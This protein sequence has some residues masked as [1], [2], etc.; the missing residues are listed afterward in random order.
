[1]VEKVNAPG[2]GIFLPVAKKKYKLAL[3]YFYFLQ[4]SVTLN[5]V[6]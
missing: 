2:R 1:M 5:P 4:I 3:K 6:N